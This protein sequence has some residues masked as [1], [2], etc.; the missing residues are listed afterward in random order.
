[1]SNDSSTRI[2]SCATLTS[3]HRREHGA[4]RGGNLHRL[5]GRAEAAGFGIKTEDDDVVRVL[6]LREQPLAGR[7]DRKVPGGFALS[8]LVV[9]A[10][11]F[12]AAG[13]NGKDRDAVMPPI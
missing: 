5:A 1:M 6:V 13:V 10:G 8:G 9:N 2:F 7:V 12:P 11:E 3:L 4:H